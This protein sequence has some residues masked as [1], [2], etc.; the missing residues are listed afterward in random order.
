MHMCEL[1]SSYGNSE[2]YCRLCGMDIGLNP[3]KEK[4][5]REIIYYCCEARANADEKD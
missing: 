2:T 3:V 5:G 1:K 4:K